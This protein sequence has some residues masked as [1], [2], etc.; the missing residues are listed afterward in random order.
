MQLQDLGVNPNR[1]LLQNG[2]LVT[3]R[4]REEGKVYVMGEILRPSAL[5]MRNGKLSL[6]EALGEAGGPNLLTANTGQVYVIRNNAQGGPAVFHL[7][8]S[9]PSC[10]GACRHFC[11]APARRGLHRPGAAG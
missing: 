4:H 11:P 7:N 9:A 3:V 1:I 10:A 8:A 2:D 5:L 6:N